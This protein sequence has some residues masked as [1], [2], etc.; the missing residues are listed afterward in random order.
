MFGMFA[1]ADY[2]YQ[3]KYLAT[4][5]VRRDASSRFSEKNRWGTFPSIS[6]GWR[7]SDEKFMEKSRTWLDDLK[8]R[9]GYGTT[10]NSNM[11]LVTVISIASMV[12]TQRYIKDLA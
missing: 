10:G 8:I 12:L 11:V 3:G 9:A 6:L 1:R 4:V 7:M 2:A 5:T